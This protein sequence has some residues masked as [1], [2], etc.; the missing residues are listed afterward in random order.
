MLIF[1]LNNKLYYFSCTID[2]R[3]Q[4]FRLQSFGLTNL[5]TVGVTS[6]PAC[7]DHLSQLYAPC[8]IHKRNT[9]KI[10]CTIDS[11]CNR[12]ILWLLGCP[13]VTCYPVIFEIITWKP[14]LKTNE[15]TKENCARRDQLYH[16]PPPP[17]ISPPPP[18]PPSPGDSPLCVFVSVKIFQFG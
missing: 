6:R 13:M 18:P 17:P 11:R 14:T 7:L 1:T 16:P 2:S 9:L 3:R 8:H 4:G 10:N 12:K 5:F 15:K